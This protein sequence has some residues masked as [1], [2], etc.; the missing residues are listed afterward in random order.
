MRKYTTEVEIR[1]ISKEVLAVK[2]VDMAVHIVYV[3]F[4]NAYWVVKPF[5]TNEAAGR[6]MGNDW[7]HSWLKGNCD[8]RI[9]GLK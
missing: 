8:R 2:I 1:F 5:W 9:F 6:Q 3:Y 7:G 4:G